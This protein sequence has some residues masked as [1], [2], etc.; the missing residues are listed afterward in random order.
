MTIH[1]T[2]VKRQT[3][4]TLA[5][6]LLLAPLPSLADFPEKP[7][8]LTV[9]Y[10][11]GGATDFQARIVTSKGDEYLG[12]PVTV[13][14]RPGAGGQIG[15][16]QFCDFV[17]LLGSHPQSSSH[18]TDHRFRFHGSIGDNLPNVFGAVFVDGVF[19]HLATPILTK[20]HIKIRH[21]HAFRVKEPLEK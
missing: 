10:S 13:I 2:S 5:V 20:I 18:V 4:S 9:A 11:A 16:N 1:A 6:C 17:A 14:N 7:L 12:Q 8:N 3:A 15:W 19:D 21:G